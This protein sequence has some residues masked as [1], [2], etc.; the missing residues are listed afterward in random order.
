M[1]LRLLLGN[2]ADHLYRG[3]TGRRDLGRVALPEVL[4][5]KYAGRHFEGAEIDRCAHVEDHR[6]H[7]TTAMM[8]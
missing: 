8:M 5:R 6:E 1:A 7:D 3:Q 4:R 2:Q